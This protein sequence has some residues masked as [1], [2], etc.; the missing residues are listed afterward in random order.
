MEPLPPSSTTTSVKDLAPFA[1]DC[2]LAIGEFSCPVLHD[3]HLIWLNILTSTYSGVQDCPVTVICTVVR[4]LDIVVLFQVASS[5]IRSSVPT[6]ACHE[7]FW[8]QYSMRST[9]HTQNSCRR[10]SA[11]WSMWSITRIS[12]V[13]TSKIISTPLPM[14]RSHWQTAPI[15]LGNVGNR[16]VDCI[17]SWTRVAHCA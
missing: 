10:R 16:Y 12:S 5:S 9:Y 15:S 11:R 7:S 2:H 14:F 17:H 8:M 3:G 6:A 4:T 1:A 13:S